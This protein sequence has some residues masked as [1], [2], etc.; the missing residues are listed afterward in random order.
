MMRTFSLAAYCLLLAVSLRAQPAQPSLDVLA[1]QQPAPLNSLADG[2]TFAISAGSVGAYGE[3][4]FTLRNRGIVEVVVRTTLSSGVEVL[5][6]QAPVLPFSPRA[7][8]TARFFVRFTAATPTR[9]FSRLIFTYRE[10]VGPQTPF[11]LNLS[12]VAPD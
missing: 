6:R 7:R 1:Q 10:T 11:T 12:G 3:A 2:D 9:A 8:E 5:M 4:V